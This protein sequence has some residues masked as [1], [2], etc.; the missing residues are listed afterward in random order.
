MKCWLF[1]A[2]VLAITVSLSADIVILRNGKKIEGRVVGSDRVSVTVQVNDFLRLKL[3]HESILEI[4]TN[5]VAKFGEDPNKVE[6][7]YQPGAN[8]GADGVPLPEVVNRNNFKVPSPVLVTLPEFKPNSTAGGFSDGKTLGV[9]GQ[10]LSDHR[11]YATDTYYF[12]RKVRD[13]MTRATIPEEQERMGRLRS[14]ATQVATVNHLNDDLR[15]GV[16]HEGPVRTRDRATEVHA[17]LKRNADEYVASY[18]RDPFKEPEYPLADQLARLDSAYR[19]YEL[20]FSTINHEEKLLVRDRIDLSTAPTKRG[21]I[22][23]DRIKDCIVTMSEARGEILKQ[24]SFYYKVGTIS[25]L[26]GKPVEVER[27]TV[28]MEEALLFPY[29]RI[30]GTAAFD[31]LLEDAEGRSIS[32]AKPVVLPEGHDVQFMQR[33]TVKYPKTDDRPEKLLEVVQVQ[34]QSGQM[35]DFRSKQQLQTMNLK[36]WMLADRIKVTKE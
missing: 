25:E 32:A 12:A 14:L 36:G 1:P 35:R 7:K 6:F 13:G 10:K 21:A 18:K 31:G 34:V 11:I 29:Q 9:D 24:F 19:S 28:A 16:M 30:E 8:M 22:L 33:K 27:W 23:R 3:Y 15:T 20:S 17:L 5:R 2:A 4:R 26:Q